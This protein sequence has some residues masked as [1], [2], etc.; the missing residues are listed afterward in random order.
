MAQHSAQ[1][2]MQLAL[3]YGLCALKSMVWAWSDRNLSLHYAVLNPHPT[4]Y[5]ACLGRC[6][7]LETRSSVMS[8]L[9]LCIVAAELVDLARVF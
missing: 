9:N 2:S 4:P 7:A 6:Q 5:T 3:R 8:T 1:R